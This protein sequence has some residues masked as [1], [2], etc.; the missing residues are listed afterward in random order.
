MTAQNPLTTPAAWN[1]VAEGYVTEFLPVFSLYAQDAIALAALSANDKVLDVA[2]G[3]GT[4]SLLAAEQVRRVTAVDFAGGMVRILNRRVAAA[5]LANVRAETADGQELPFEKDTFHAAFSMFG[6]MFFPNRDAGF[7]ELNR[8]LKPGGRAVVSSWAPVSEAPLL[9]ALFDCLG[10]LLPDLAFGGDAPPPLSDAGVFQ[11]EMQAA[12]FRSVK[13]H[14]VKHRVDVPSVR[15]FWA[16]QEKASA[17]IVLLRSTLSEEE[18]QDVSV[19]VIEGVE[20]KFGAGP[21]SLAW[22]ARLGVGVA[23]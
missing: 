7:R 18:W 3:P 2:A 1:A 16:S 10:S 14:T 4:L 5:G 8:V 13:I 11:D 12:G 17:P 22:P 20:K 23:Q 15:Q 21:L 9:A 6:L 19:K